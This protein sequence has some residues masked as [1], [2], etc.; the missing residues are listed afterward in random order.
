MLISNSSCIHP[1]NSLQRDSLVAS[2]IV[3]STY[4]YTNKISLPFSLCEE[5]DVNFINVKT[6]INK[7]KF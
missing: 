7:K 6:I 5:G 2:N 1:A 4:I 3:T